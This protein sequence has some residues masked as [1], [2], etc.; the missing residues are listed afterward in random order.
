MMKK[1][2]SVAMVALMIFVLCASPV[3]A[4]K[5]KSVNL[6]PN[7]S[8]STDVKCTLNKNILGKPKAGVVR[9]S[10]NNW[11]VN[12]DIRMRNGSKVIWSQNNAIRSSGTSAWVYRDFNL[13]NNYN[14]Y[15]LSFR[16]S[17]SCQVAPGVTV[18]N[19][20]NCNIS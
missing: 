7:R 16:C 13:G 1:I 11:G 19:I 9:V 20:K 2:L 8:W 18:K 12:V 3:S 10:I 17:K 5:S 14:Y 15:N 4:A 6:A